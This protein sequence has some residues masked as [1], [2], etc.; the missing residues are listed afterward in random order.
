MG[1]C[2]GAPLA[3]CAVDAECP[4]HQSCEAGEC[5]TGC[6]SD[7]ECAGGQAC[8]A[9]GRC[10][11]DGEPLDFGVS[12]PGDSSTVAAPDLLVPLSCGDGVVQ[13]GEACDD[14]AA[15]SDLAAQAAGC[16]SQCRKRASCGGLGGSSAAQLDPST[17]HCYVVWPG[18]VSWATAERQCETAGGTLASIGSAGEDAIAKAV[19]AGAPRWIGLQSATPGMGNFAWVTGEPIGYTGFAAGDPDNQGG[20][21]ECVRLDP[22]SGWDDVACGWP[23]S[24]LLAAS[25]SV[26]GGFV[27]EL[28]CGNG[29]VEPGEGCDPPGPSCT[30]TCQ[31]RRACP[32][33]GG[34]VSPVNGHCYFP[35][36]ATG[37]FD[38]AMTAC[39]AGTHLATLGGIAETEAA[40][41]AITTDSWIALRAGNGNDWS[42]QAPGRG[43]NARTY[44]G[45]VAGEP[46][47]GGAACVRVRSDGWADQACSVVHPALCE[48]E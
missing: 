24:G 42:W 1:S 26:T 48:R 39:P 14:G 44:H 47:Q 27:C 23:A 45:F 43:F 41:Q 7:G 2:G 17:G 35:T 9:H 21:E 36:A 13:A 28:S 16:T 40:I 15:N 4:L 25:P 11:G 22:A 6:F 20:V 19:G 46:N 33:A 8:T 18:P 31:T 10:L 38:Q 5:R 12:D 37:T 29:I 30:A 3:A 32:E 34:V